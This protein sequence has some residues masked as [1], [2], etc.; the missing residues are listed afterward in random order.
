MREGEQKPFGGSAQFG[1]AS[2]RKELEKTEN[3]P[4]TMSH[5][6]LDLL[7]G[8]LDNITAV[9]THT[10]ATKT[11]LAELAASLAVSVDTVARQQIEIKRLIEHINT[12]RKKGVSVT[13]SV[14]SRGYNNDRTCKHFKAVGRSTPHRNNQ[15]FFDPRKT[16]TDW[17][18]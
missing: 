3:N 7:E 13:V 15:C 1:P 6:I 5:K 12:L 14:P 18:G 10:A 17:I 4:P 11:P 9:A 16:N 2:V 8:D